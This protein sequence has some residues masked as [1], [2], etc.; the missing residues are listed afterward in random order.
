M[1]PCFWYYCPH[2]DS[3]G[4]F[5]HVP[6]ALPYMSQTCRKNSFIPCGEKE[7]THTSRRRPW[8]CL[9]PAVSKPQPFS[10]ECAKLLLYTC[11]LQETALSVAGHTLPPFPCF[12]SLSGIIQHQ[13]ADQWWL[14]I[15]HSLLTLCLWSH[16]LSRQASVWQIN[17]DWSLNTFTSVCVCLP[18]SFYPFPMQIK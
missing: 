17:E 15:L 11:L 2:S 13:S 3:T 5:A 4:Y 16:P 9:D 6:W 10:G 18:L 14:S 8:Q 1:D 12:S 7:N